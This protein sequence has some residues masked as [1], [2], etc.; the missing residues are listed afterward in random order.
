M[1]MNDRIKAMYDLK[2]ETLRKS[3]CY[4]DFIENLAYLHGFLNA[5]DVSGIISKDEHL[6]ESMYIS[7]VASSVNYN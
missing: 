7:N 3:S 2:V 1:S 6:K 4:D 5:L